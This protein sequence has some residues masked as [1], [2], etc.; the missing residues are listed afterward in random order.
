MDNVI[1]SLENAQTISNAMNWLTMKGHSPSMRW[2]HWN[3]SNPVITIHV[4]TFKEDHTFL[5]AMAVSITEQ[6]QIDG[7]SKKWEDH[8]LEVAEA[9]RV[10]LRKKSK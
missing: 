5:D 3:P 4:R 9:E 8:M 7:F 2:E 10:E 1:Y 6:W